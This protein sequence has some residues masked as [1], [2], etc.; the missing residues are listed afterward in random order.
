MVRLQEDGEVVAIGVSNFSL[1]EVK[2]CEAIPH[3]DSLQPPFSAIHRDA[4]NLLPWCL[5]HNV[6]VLVYSPMQSGLLTDSFSAER[7]ERLPLTDMRRTK[8]EFQGDAL[9]QNLSV[10]DA[11]R[12]VAT[13]QG[14][15][16]AAAAVAWTLQWPGVTG[17]IVGA[18]SAHQVEGWL[19]AASLRF[20]DADLDLVADAIERVGAGAGS[21]RPPKVD[22]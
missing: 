6:S 4:A 12:D 5:E 16:T 8:P 9:W 22:S 18:R 2:H 1:S 15:S 21:T 10:R 11:I 17:A 3:V 13:R 20:S 7:F 14:V 19:P